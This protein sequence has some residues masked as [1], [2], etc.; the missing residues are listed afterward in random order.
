MASNTQATI[1]F[2]G[3]AGDGVAS[4]G[5]IFLRTCS[6][7]GL[8]VFAYNSY[9]SV[10]RGGL[11]LLQVQVGSGETLHQGTS[12]YDLMIA[13]SQDSLDL[14]LKSVIA[15]PGRGIIFNK[16]K[17]KLDPAKLPAGATAY[18]LPVGE[19]TKEYGGNPIMQNTLASGAIVYLLGLS[20]DIFEKSI[21]GI[22]GKKKPEIAEL[23]IKI[24][25]KGY[26]FAKAN[27]RPVKE[28]SLKGDGKKRMLVTGNQLIAL[29]LVAGGCNF[30]S[31][32]PMTPASGIMHW[33]ALRA[34]KYGL[35]M[36]Q[37][38]DE[39]A[40]INMSIGAGF[41]GVRSATG[42]S[43]G[44]F[45]LMSEGVGLAGMTETPV[46]VVEVQRGGPS[47]GLPT[48]TEQGDLFEVL[49]AS[50]GEYPKAV[51]APLSVTDAYYAAVESLNL[52]EKYQMPVILISD[53]Y[54]SEHTESIFPDKLTN[55]VKIE[56][57]EFA[58]GL[59]GEGPYKR[60]L[61]TPSGVS[62]RAVPGMA[63]GMH[64]NASD[65]HDEDGALISDIFSNPTTRVKIMNKRMRKLEGVLKEIKPFIKEGPETAD[66]TLVGW[67]STYQILR[68]I[69]LVLEKE[70]AKVNQ[71]QFR[72]L[73]PFKSDVVE[74]A[75]K[76]CK[77]TVCIENN[78]S[79]LFARLVRQETGI[80]FHHHIR[81]YDGE[82]FY[83]KELLEKV[84]D[85]LK[86]G[87]PNVQTLVSSELDI[88]IKRMVITA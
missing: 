2:G 7:S 6:R 50:Q 38:E 61:D 39:I 79:G 81:K 25:R 78:F 52:A 42:T 11:V 55:K 82:P 75:L 63:G 59:N 70:G 86:G 60:F 88:P 16:D 31:A 69:R 87:A 21:Q 12:R 71:I 76:A 27:F 64:T 4:T 22:F 17:V 85:C 24:A 54:L 29:G 34:G 10:I 73:W 20:W 1:W 30:F 15:A 8:N 3:A 66:L 23:N 18:G 46:V 33:L 28:I 44:G 80:A 37:A 51:M 36:K 62:P 41:A 40:A 14:H 57:G 58:A 19:L 9:Q 77:K 84:K 48:K 68:D 13:L 32:Y 43:G 47:T 45:S 65:E 67:G 74:S 53:L 83:A 5:E 72:V 26:E 35:V 49:G 56:R